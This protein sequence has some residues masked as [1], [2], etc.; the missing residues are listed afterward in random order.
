[1]GLAREIAAWFVGSAA[2]LYVVQRLADLAAELLALVCDRTTLRFALASFVAITGLSFLVIGGTASV[3]SHFFNY[4]SV[5]ASSRPVDMR[6]FLRAQ[7][8]CDKDSIEDLFFDGSVFMLPSDT[9][10]TCKQHDADLSDCR[11]RSGPYRGEIVVVP[12]KRISPVS[13]GQR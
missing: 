5:P 3:P 1:M 7:R 2:I 9:E 11:V 10:L 13:G 4:Y 8:Q 6:E 12:S